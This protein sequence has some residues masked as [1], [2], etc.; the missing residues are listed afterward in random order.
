MELRFR[1]SDPFCHG[2]Y[3][4]VASAPNLLMKVKYKKNKRT[5]ET[6][7]QTSLE[8]VVTTGV[9]F[10]GKLKETIILISF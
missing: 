6:A 1:P 5:Q 2:V 4:D 10:K 9:S 8:G 3:G 7:F